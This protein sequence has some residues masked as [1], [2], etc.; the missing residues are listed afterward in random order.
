[1]L[2]TLSKCHQSLLLPLYQLK[3]DCAVF[4]LKEIIITFVQFKFWYL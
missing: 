4:R 1:M 3:M 2:H